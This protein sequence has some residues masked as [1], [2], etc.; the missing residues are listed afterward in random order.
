MVSYFYEAG[1][2]ASKYDTSKALLYAQVAI[3]ADKYNCASLYRLAKNLFGKSVEVVESNKWRAIAAFIYNFT[4]IEALARREI[5]NAVVTA[6]ASCC[7]MLKSTLQNKTVVDL[8]CSNADLATDLLLGR[9]YRTTA[10][11]IGEYHFTY[12]YCCYSHSGLHNYPN[13]TSIN[14]SNAR[15]CPKCCKGTGRKV[16]HTGKVKLYL[17]FSC[18]L[19]DGIH[20]YYLELKS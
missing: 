7:Y 9:Q 2:N 3:L 15:I 6:V 11:N 14:E 17:A 12:D 4:T 13:V 10:K 18:T 20:S 8:L 16:S 1:Y 19:C 5:R